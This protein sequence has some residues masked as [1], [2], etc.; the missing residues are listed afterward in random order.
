M[1][2]SWV[3]P[4]HQHLWWQQC[5]CRL[6]LPS[7]GHTTAVRFRPSFHSG[8]YAACRCVPLMSNV[9]PQRMHPVLPESVLASCKSKSSR[10]CRLQIPASALPSRHAAFGVGWLR[11]PVLPN[12]IVSG[13][14]EG[15]RDQSPVKEH[16]VSRALRVHSRPRSALGGTA[17]RRA[18]PLCVAASNR[19]LVSTSSTSYE[20]WQQL[21][22][23]M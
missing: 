12:R 3:E 2:L 17:A 16:F 9:R 1:N 21:A 7:S 5:G 15:V 13:A 6:T 10:Q 4:V 18:T 20:S 23:S 14:A 11:S 19:R 22:L 8:P